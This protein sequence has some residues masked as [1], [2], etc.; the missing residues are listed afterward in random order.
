MHYL[1]EPIWNEFESTLQTT[2]AKKEYKREILAI[3]QY[4]KKKYIL[5][6]RLEIQAYFNFLLASHLKPSTIL[7]KQAKLRSFS[8]YLCD[9][10][11]RFHIEYKTNP[12]ISINFMPDSSFYIAAD[13]VPSVSEIDNIFSEASSCPEV[14]LI[15]SLLVKCTISPGELC[16]IRLSDFYLDETGY[17]YLK[18][19]SKGNTRSIKITSDIVDII[20]SYVSLATPTTYLFENRN[21]NQLRLRDMER[22]FRKLL[23]TCTY[24]LS[25]I[26]NSG[27]AI[28]LAQGIPHIQ[29][30][31]Y[32]GITPLWLRRFE[33][34]LPQLGV[35]AIDLSS[36]QIKNLIVNP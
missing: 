34:Q 29:V 20:N 12:F 23:P 15:L 6:S 9:N 4:S 25:D 2:Q 11:A 5:L 27:I 3:C 30:A 33:K 8:N 24:T 10:A 13:H 17:P 22:H 35:Q 31:A 19:V 16:R 36:L 7:S 14:Y 26:R 18:I 21:G 28:M 32:A 1:D